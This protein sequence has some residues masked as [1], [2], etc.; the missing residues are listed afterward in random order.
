MMNKIKAVL[1]V[2]V[3]TLLL[4]LALE[5][6]LRVYIHYKYGVPG[7]SYGIYQSDP[8]LGAVHRPNSYNSNSVINNWG[9]R[10]VEDI[11]E[12]K[13]EGA[14]RV[15][16]SGGSTTFCYN[17]K[18]EEAWPSLLERR[19]RRLP[20]HARDQ[21]LNA[22]QVAF[23]LSHE[24]ALAKRLVPR[25][26]PDLTVLYGTGINEL[27]AGF[28]LIREKRDLDAL[29]AQ[30]KWGVFSKNLDQAN[31][32]KRNSALV[33]FFDYKFKHMLQ[34]S[35][36]RRFLSQIAQDNGKDQPWIDKN[37]EMTLRDYIRFLKGRGSRVLLVRYGDSGVEAAG[38]RD[39]ALIFRDR[40]SAIAVEEGASVVDFASLVEKRPDRKDLFI[41]SGL[42]VNMRG[43]DLLA[44]VLLDAISEGGPAHA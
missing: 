8:E 24:F 43:A 3:L 40:A 28:A 17:L 23:S 13:P 26:E 1:T 6:G 12:R 44:D 2:I 21:V 32:I 5:A 19:L 30:R 42:H 7:K 34:E 25:L 38:V 16:C 35:S 18:T 9:L 41:D 39:A 36:R 29:L 20:G 37:F 11:D 15:Y 33:K 10:N 31:G 22:G 4:A 14:L 27:A